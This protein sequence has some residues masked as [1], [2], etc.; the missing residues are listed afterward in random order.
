M[1]LLIDIGNTNTSLALTAGKRIVKRYFIS[2]SK[3]EVAPKS[4]IRL[5]GRNVSK[6]DDIVIVSV[7]PK[8]L[9]VIKKSLKRVVP[10]ATIRLMGKDIKVPIKIKYKDPKQ[11]GQ[12]RL[13]TALSAQEAYGKPVLII[14]FGTAVTFDMVGEHGG[15]E[16]GLIFPG[17]RLGLEALTKHAALLPDI[18]LRP[19]TG[20]IGRDTDGSMNKGLLYG[21]ASMCDGMIK[22][23]REKYGRKL[24]VVATGGDAEL[25]ARYSKYIRNVQP[26]LMTNGLRFLAEASETR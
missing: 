21:Y 1:K 12:D 10:N 19:A 18:D 22:R 6:I 23:F 20:L 17:L 24:K 5:F 14:D 3:V 4:L 25:V 16:G 13:V 8:F 7:V 26:D 11:V 2:T 9:S 15:Y